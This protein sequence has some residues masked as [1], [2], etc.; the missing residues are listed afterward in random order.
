MGRVGG[1]VLS[2]CSC[3]D[4]LFLSIP[5][6]CSL[7]ETAVSSR[8][9]TPSPL[10]LQQIALHKHNAHTHTHAHRT[11]MLSVPD[12]VRRRS[13][14]PD[15]SQG[16]H[17]S[18]RPSIGY[19]RSG[20]DE[21]PARRV[22]VSFRRPLVDSVIEAS[23]V[24][25]RQ[26]GQQ[27]LADLEV[28]N[29]TRDEMMRLVN[30]PEFDAWRLRAIHRENEKYVCRRASMHCIPSSHPHLSDTQKLGSQC[31]PA[32]PRHP[33]SA[34]VRRCHALQPHAAVGRSS[35]DRRCLG[36]SRGNA[37]WFLSD[38]DCVVPFFPCLA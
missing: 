24:S 37:S 11:N 38:A 22:S 26:S 36:L 8:R 34:H 18:H 10:R 15:V 13:V 33:C 20:L 2:C 5:L 30:Q 35:R 27:T 31:V 6:L 4:P 7:E 25:H 19:R 29:H 17:A 23:A 28:A 3:T 14:E 12:S 21:T 1:S 32:H 9:G 16:A